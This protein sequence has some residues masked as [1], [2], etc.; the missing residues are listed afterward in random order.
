MIVAVHLHGV[1]EEE[2]D[3]EGDGGAEGEAH[4][5]HAVQG[6][7]AVLSP[8]KEIYIYIYMQWIFSLFSAS[9]KN[10]LVE[11]L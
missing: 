3:E 10:M 1:K 2:H 11:T 6:R 9:L 8:E 4:R 5:L 7:H